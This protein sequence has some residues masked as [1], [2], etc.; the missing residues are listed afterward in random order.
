MPKSAGSSPSNKIVFLVFL[1]AALGLGA[2]AE[3]VRNTPDAARVPTALRR[4]ANPPLSSPNPRIS[5]PR[6]TGNDDQVAESTQR[7]PAFFLPVVKSGK[8]ELSEPA[9]Q[10]PDGAD[11]KAYLANEAL[12]SMSVGEGAKV[13]GVDVR[14]RTALLELNSAFVDH[15]F[16]S[17]EEGQVVEALQRVMGQFDDIDKVQLM[18]SGEPIDSL[19]HIDL[20]EAIP[21][22]RPGSSSTP[23]E[24]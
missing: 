17:T 2:L 13:L 19:G 23:S 10:V 15:G 11:P 7:A 16:G 8:V 22:I 12:K 24:E 1:V 4:D 5:H 3:Y 6:V 9:P 14:N 21:V 20:G 18:H